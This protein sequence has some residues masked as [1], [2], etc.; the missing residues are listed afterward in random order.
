MMGLIHMDM[1]SMLLQLTRHLLH[2]SELTAAEWI[3]LISISVFFIIIGIV[4]Y[5]ALS[6]EMKKPV[7]RA[8][9]Q[10]PWW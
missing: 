10:L 7:R 4:I 2:P 1:L 6:I 3:F 5:K 8:N 9:G